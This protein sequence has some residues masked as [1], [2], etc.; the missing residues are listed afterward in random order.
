MDEDFVREVLSLVVQV[1]GSVEKV[2]RKFSH[3]Q[4]PPKELHEFR[5]S[6]NRLERKIY[7]FT[8]YSTLLDRIPHPEDVDQIKET[9][10]LC[11]SLFLKTQERQG[12]ELPVGQSVVLKS[13]WLIGESEELAKYTSRINEHYSTIVLP[14]TLQLALMNLKYILK[15]VE[16]LSF[17][18][19]KQ[20]T[21]IHRS[22]P[23]PDQDAGPDSNT[24]AN[25]LSGLPQ[26][27][28]GLATN[29]EKILSLAN[30]S[31]RDRQSSDSIDR[32]GRQLDEAFHR[33]NSFKTRN[34]EPWTGCQ[35]QFPPGHVRISYPLFRSNYIQILE[36]APTSDH[37]I[38]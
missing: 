8:E 23:V 6:I 3:L 27:A 22:R 10:R 7:D 20:L 30:H 24:G 2:I 21:I 1:T 5:Y 32:K 12:K 34:I 16:D 29:V 35:I 28:G 14:T 18:D 33:R 25:R 37:Q 17:L 31:S 36:M 4:D 13:V 15:P 11:V 38:D 19:F 26:P 9:L